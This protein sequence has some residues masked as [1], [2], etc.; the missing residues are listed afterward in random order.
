MRLV[1]VL[2]SDL[3]I[4]SQLIALLVFIWG[5]KVYGIIWYE[6]VLWPRFI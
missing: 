2:C 6:V 4:C 1:G 5:R 3:S